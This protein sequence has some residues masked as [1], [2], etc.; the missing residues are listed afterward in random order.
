MPIVATLTVIALLRGDGPA[1]PFFEPELLRDMLVDGLDGIA[2]DELQDA[3]AIADELESKMQRYR[4]RVDA[5]IDAYIEDSSNP[6]TDAAD[7]TERLAPLD[8]DRAEIMNA[9]IDA[10]RR[11]VAI[12]DA[13]R[14]DEV[15]G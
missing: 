12:L 2:N 1:A 5:S 14:W 11:L 4:M 8:S 6:A 3:L 7:L 9:V 15:F 10:R 13:E